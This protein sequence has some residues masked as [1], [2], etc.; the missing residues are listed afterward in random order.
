MCMDG[1][2]WYELY[3]R[4]WPIGISLEAHNIDHTLSDPVRGDE[5]ANPFLRDWYGLYKQVRYTYMCDT[6]C[7]VHGAEGLSSNPF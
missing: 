2:L 6:A 5:G 7:A 4:R 1:Q 3:K